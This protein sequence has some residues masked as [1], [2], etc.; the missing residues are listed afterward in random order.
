MKKSLFFICLTALVLTSCENFLKGSDLRD[1]LEEAIEIA[2]TS[3]VTFIV[4]ADENS[5]TLKTFTLQLKKKN[6]FDVV[7][8]PAETYKFIKWEVLD[9]TTKEPVEGI[10]KFDDET[11]PE[12]KGIAIAPREGLEIH[13]KCLL[14]PAVVSVNPSPQ[15]QNQVNA[16]IR[17]KFNMPLNDSAVDNVS[18]T[19]FGQEMDDYFEK[20]VLNA[21]KDELTIRPRTSALIT[22]IDNLK[23]GFTDIR[24]SL[25]SSITALIDGEPVPLYQNANASFDFHYIL[26]YDNNPPYKNDFYLSR[27]FEAPSA[28]TKPVS[29]F[30]DD[31]KLIGEDGC[32]ASEFETVNGVGKILD[33]ASGTCIYIY[34]NYRENE[35]AIETIRVYEQFCG[36]NN[37]WYFG[38]KVL[39]AQYS[40]N[41]DNVYYFIDDDANTIF[42]IKHAIKSADGAV[43]VSIDVEDVYGNST[44][45]LTEI[46]VFNMA[47]PPF[48]DSGKYSFQNN[49]MTSG[50]NERIYNE[51]IKTVNFYGGEDEDVCI[52]YCWTKIPSS[53]YTVKCEYKHK[54]G[55]VYAEEFPNTNS[56]CDWFLDLDV[57]QMSG[58]QLKLIVTDIFGNYWEKQYNI[59]KS[60]DYKGIIIPDAD[61]PSDKANVMF[62]YITGEQPYAINQLIDNKGVLSY[63]TAPDHDYEMYETVA[64]IDKNV[65]YRFIPCVGFDPGASNSSPSAFFYTE[66]PAHTYSMTG[67][68][69][70]LSNVVLKNY[71]GTD[72]PYRIT[73]NS[74][75]NLLNV[76]VQISEN[77]PEDYD[78]I[79]MLVKDNA[80]ITGLY[81]EAHDVL[82]GFGE[83]NKYA[84]FQKDAAT[85][86]FNTECTVTAITELMFQNPTDI[87][88]YGLKNGIST[89]GI[90]N[91]IELTYN[92]TACDNYN[93]ADIDYQYKNVTVNDCETVTVFFMDEQ[94]GISTTRSCIIEGN[95]I[96]TRYGNQLSTSTIRNIEDSG[97]FVRRADLTGTNDVY[98][99]K[100][101]FPRWLFTDT[102]FSYQ[103][104]DRAGNIQ[105][106]TIP[107]NNNQLYHILRLETKDSEK[108]SPKTEINVIAQETSGVKVKP[109]EI[110]I[111]Q[112]GGTTLKR[113][114]YSSEVS[115]QL[116]ASNSDFPSNTFIKVVIK[117]P[118]ESSSPWNRYTHPAYIYTGKSNSGAMDYIYPP[119]NGRIAINS[120]APVLARTIVTSVP[121]EECKNWSIAK[122]ENGRHCIREEVLN[123]DGSTHAYYKMYDTDND[124]EGAT[125]YAVIVHFADGTKAMSQIMQK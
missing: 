27:T 106:G 100:I 109:E 86:K 35:S 116:K 115:L 12:T 37:N 121:Y 123:C 8:E 47:K 18:L 82:T 44:N 56:G 78:E 22:F 6:T 14:Q 51:Q 58:L 3:P 36:E 84:G 101:E 107:V 31:I 76:T 69:A 43:R 120:D 68:N 104:S 96:L 55:S 114:T 25:P 81:N 79:I 74:V 53:Y 48:C 65:T 61:N 34:G 9:R 54:D 122:W 108:N 91:T 99:G 41:D 13:A 30:H 67:S 89:A 10:L 70:A 5:G 80:L 94:T 59:P 60:E 85:G 125:C 21:A 119:Y 7:F 23:K 111:Y 46:T 15:G 4:T 117:L 93:N 63:D 1:Q 83:G 50:F 52:P 95:D 28:N 2:N 20:P 72:L 57:E 110:V 16:A 40:I 24:V 102:G 19:C 73:K 88:V 77:Q 45:D 33:N 66:V 39:A 92:D 26:T 75:K 32:T 17:I 87:V 112:M 64:N 29:R 71:E 42:C 105:S 11:N 98:D 113:I 118:D 90:G 49:R 38:Q 103:F 62:Y 124:I 97:R